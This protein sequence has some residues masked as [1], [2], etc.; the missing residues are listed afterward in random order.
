MFMTAQ[1][2]ARGKPPEA[3][4][5]YTL[6]HFLPADFRNAD[7]ENLTAAGLSEGVFRTVNHSSVSVSAVLTSAPLKA[8]FPFDQLLL[9]ANA[10]LGPGDTLVCQAQVKTGSGWSPWFDFGSFD[11]AGG[12]A[13]VRN[14]ENPFGRMETDILILNAK[15][16]YL[17][18]RIKLSARA[19]STPCLRLVSAVYTDTAL[20][21]DEAAAVKRAADFKPVKLAIPRYSQMLAAVKYSKDICSPTSLA[22][23][24]SYFGIRTSPLDAAAMVIDNTE[25]IYGN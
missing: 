12:S 7:T 17:R 6:V 14:Q 24:L 18:Y 2:K 1:I 23:V 9:T 3:M 13:S 19:D 25:N 11:P 16:R 8:L 5:S 22:M 20:P 4:R 21:Y 15:A 10:A